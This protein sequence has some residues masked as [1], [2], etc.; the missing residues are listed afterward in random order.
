MIADPNDHVHLAHDNE[1]AFHLIAIVAAIIIVAGTFFILN[2]MSKE[3]EEASVQAPPALNS[4]PLANPAEPA[5][6][7]PAL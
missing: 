1:R 6:K 7:T 2:S 3:Y 5:A 4:V